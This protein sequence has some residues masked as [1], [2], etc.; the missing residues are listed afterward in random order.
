MQVVVSVAHADRAVG[1]LSRGVGAWLQQ[2]GPM[3][4]DTAAASLGESISGMGLRE[5]ILCFSGTAIT[6]AGSAV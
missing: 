3:V 4:E 5:S 6:D 1:S 2:S